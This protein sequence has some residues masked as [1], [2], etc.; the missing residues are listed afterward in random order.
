MHAHMLS[1][2]KFANYILSNLRYSSLAGMINIP[3]VRLQ[4]LMNS[5]LVA[6]GS[7]QMVMPRP[8]MR[9][10]ANSHFFLHIALPAFYTESMETISLPICIYCCNSTREGS[11]LL[12]HHLSVSTISQQRSDKFGSQRPYIYMTLYQIKCFSILSS[13][14]QM[15]EFD[16]TQCCSKSRSSFGYRRILA[17]SSA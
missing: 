15:D 10:F 12:P 2:V 1:P 13:G 14:I 11:T 7:Y 5:A 3:L 17:Y 6:K 4:D 16:W 9:S 8:R